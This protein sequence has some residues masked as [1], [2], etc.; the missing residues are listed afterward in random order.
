M[1]LRDL[2]PAGICPVCLRP[3]VLKKDGALRKHW[4]RDGMGKGLPFSDPCTGTGGQPVSFDQLTREQQQE[5]TNGP[6]PGRKAED[7]DAH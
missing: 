6:M 5:F 4:A 7:H 3:F 1:T 2:Q